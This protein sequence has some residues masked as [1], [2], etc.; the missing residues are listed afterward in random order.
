[1]STWVLLQGLA[2][3]Y[4]SPEWTKET[5]ALEGAAATVGLAMGVQLVAFWSHTTTDGTNYGQ[6]K[7]ICLYSAVLSL[8]VTQTTTQ[9]TVTLK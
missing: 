3:F 1:M 7:L 8:Q 9:H 5:L 4:S 6:M 2:S